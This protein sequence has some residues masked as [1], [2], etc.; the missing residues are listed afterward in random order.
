MASTRDVEER[1]LALRHEYLRRMASDPLFQWQPTDKQRPFIRAVLEGVVPECHLVA[2]NRAGKSAAGSYCGAMLARFGYDATGDHEPTGA[3]TPTNGWVVTVTNK[4]SQEVIQPKYFDNGYGA[5]I[6]SPPFIPDREIARWS[7][8]DQIL[9]LKNG[10]MISFKSLEQGREKFQGAGLDWIHFD[11]EPTK[12]IYEECV[13]RVSAGR[14]LRIFGT[15]TLLPPE[16]TVGGISWMYSN[17]IQPWEAGLRRNQ[18]AVFGASIYDNPHISPDEIARL[19]AIYPEGSIQRRIRLNGEWLPGL[20]GSRAYTAFSRALHVQPQP[21]LH[22]RRPLCWT[23]DFNVEPMVSLIG[24]REGSLF[25]F[26]R[27][28]V[29][30][31]GNIQ[32]M[33]EW[34]RQL[35]PTWT[36]EIWIYGDATGKGRT[37]QTGQ[38]DYQ[39]IVNGMRSYGPPVRLKVP[40]SNPLVR[41]RV[42]AMNR[43]LKDEQG[44]INVLVDPSCNELITDFEQVLMDPRGGIRKTS[45]RT[46]PYYR[47]SHLSD[48]AGYWVIAEAPVQAF[49]ASPPAIRSVPRITR[50]G[51]G[52]TGEKPW[53]EAE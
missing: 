5:G 10:S 51:Y 3:E 31:E 46:D 17:I 38:S 29:L 15:C 34:F 1:V 28:L 37:A 18:V 42:N 21:P 9:K 26:H 13:I 35:F 14:K 41:D 12:S 7:V 40:E 25:R 39:L 36:A 16:G 45:N 52:F 30:E 19:E 4:T 49:T 6:T 50:P 53:A 44:Q 33:V 43:A 47:R 2:S 27:E 8:T 20:S 11:E 48:S 23:W 22:P 32:E 24:Q